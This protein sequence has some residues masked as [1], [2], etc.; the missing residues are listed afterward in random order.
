MGALAL[1]GNVE[2]WGEVRFCDRT[3]G[4]GWRDVINTIFLFS[5]NT[6]GKNK[7]L[8]SSAGDAQSAWFAPELRT[9][10]LIFSLKQP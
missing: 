7:S 2:V 5:E 6:L 4:R 10:L 3:E 9:V 8:L 1:G